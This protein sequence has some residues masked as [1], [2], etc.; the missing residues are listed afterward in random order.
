MPGPPFWHI[1]GISFLTVYKRKVNWPICRKSIIYETP[2]GSLTEGYIFSEAANSP[3]VRVLYKMLIHHACGHIKDLLPLMNETEVDMIESVSPPPTG[4]IDISGAF[5]LIGKEKGIIGGIEPAFSVSS[6]SI[7]PMGL[8]RVSI[9]SSPTN[10][11]HTSSPRILLNSSNGL[12]TCVGLVTLVLPSPPMY[13]WTAASPTTF[14]LFPKQKRQ[15]I[16]QQVILLHTQRI[17]STGMDI[18]AVNS[19]G[20]KPRQTD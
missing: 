5:S 18:A 10:S 14:S 13:G 20:L 1:T 17:H 8:L 11:I 4:N 2:V 12:S 15:C 19:N 3:G 9:F 6:I 16:L 7:C